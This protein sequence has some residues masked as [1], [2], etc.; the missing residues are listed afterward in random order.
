MERKLD[1]LKKAITN[2]DRAIRAKAGIR[3][4]RTNEVFTAPLQISASTGAG[5]ESPCTCYVCLAK[6]KR[7]LTSITVEFKS[8]ALV[9]LT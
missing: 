2:H 8:S 4:A 6:F 1:Q 3:V 5:F 7:F 9:I